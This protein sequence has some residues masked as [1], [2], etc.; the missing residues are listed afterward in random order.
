MF[1]DPLGLKAKACNVPPIGP[2]SKLPTPIKR[3]ASGQL[4]GCLIE[5]ESSGDPKAKS[6][7]GAEGLMQVTPIT[8]AAAA[9]HGLVQP[10]MTK[11]DIAH[12]YLN[13]LVT[14]CQN[15]TYALAAYNAGPTAVNAAGGVPNNGETPDYVRKI[16]NC[17]KKQLH[18]V[19]G[20][21][22][23]SVTGGCCK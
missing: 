1:I 13:L 8:L 5:T 7:A 18:V 20:L 11:D 19:G 10:D 21:S 14:Y 4:V 2:H 17:L 15:I 16:D 9:Q 23:P 3:C 12:A 22:N 6:S